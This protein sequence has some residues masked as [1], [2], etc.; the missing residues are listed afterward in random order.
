MAINVGKPDYYS[1]LKRRRR[2]VSQALAEAGVISE[3]GLKDLIDSLKS[4]YLISQRFL[5]EAEAYVSSLEL[6]EPEKQKPVKVV[7]NKQEKPVA[8]GQEPPVEAEPW[9]KAEKPKPAPPRRKRAKKTS[10]T[11]KPAAKKQT[12]SS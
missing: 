6:P 1:V 2:T 4:R 3:T 8:A 12:E 11:K 5:H 9:L 10:S 7:D